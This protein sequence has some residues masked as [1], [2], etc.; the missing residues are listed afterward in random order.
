M[1]AISSL[2]ALC[3]SITSVTMFLSILTSRYL[4]WD[5]YYSLPS[6]LILGLSSLFISIVSILVSFC[7]GHFLSIRDKLKFAVFP[8]YAFTC[9]PLTLFAVAQFPLYL[10]LIR[11]IMAPVPKRSLEVTSI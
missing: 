10:D 11:S 6:K 9:L 7:S 5:F 1:F 4:V 2:A 8:I 3:F